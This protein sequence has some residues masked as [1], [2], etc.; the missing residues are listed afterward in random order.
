MKFHLFLLHLG[1]GADAGGPARHGASLRDVGDISRETEIHQNSTPF[2]GNSLVD[3][4]S[5]WPWTASI[6]WVRVGGLLSIECRTGVGVGKWAPT[7]WG[8]WGRPKSG[9]PPLASQ[10]SDFEGEPVQPVLFDASCPNVAVPVGFGFRPGP[11]SGFW[12]G[13]PE[14]RHICATPNPI[15]DSIRILHRAGPQHK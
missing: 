13:G 5:G 11:N 9:V 4:L 15:V 8:G 1:R 12:E 14:N 7:P 3:Q 6:K 10:N 2:A